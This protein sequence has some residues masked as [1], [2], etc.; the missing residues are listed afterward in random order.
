MITASGAEYAYRYGE[1]GRITEVE[2]ARQVTSVKNLYDRRFRI[3][4]QEFPDGGT[5]TFAYDDKNRRVTLTERNGSKIIHVH[6]DRYR[7]IETI[8]EDGTKEKYLY[9]DKNQCISKTDRLGRTTRMAYD[10]RGNLTQTV[11]A[12][13]RRV[14]YTY[15]AD[16]HLLSVSINGKERLKNHYDAKEI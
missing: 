13:K 12:M 10:N 16:C 4:H 14:N 1:N 8:Y 6:D 7:N 3:I 15:D 2:N 11:D 9:N 5:M